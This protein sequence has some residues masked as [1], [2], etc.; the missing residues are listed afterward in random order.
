M[1]PEAQ[2]QRNFMNDINWRL[3]SLDT[4]IRI[5]E[6]NILNEGRRIQLIS[7]NFLEFKKE[8]R[9]KLEHVLEENHEIDK[10]FSDISKDIE[11]LEL[12]Q[13][14]METRVKPIPIRIQ[15]AADADEVLENVLKMLG[16]PL[17]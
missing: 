14:R 17:K 9:E 11:R 6:Q 15:A 5:N 13:K 7:K 16:K 3:S 10:K 12:L 2:S 1:T 4:K 8:I